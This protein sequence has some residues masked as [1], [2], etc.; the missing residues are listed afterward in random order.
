M[1]H[2]SA[3]DQMQSLSQPLN[4]LTVLDTM[5]RVFATAQWHL[6]ASKTPR[7]KIKDANFCQT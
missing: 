3:A 1:L 6:Y 4:K 5:L 2:G 7:G